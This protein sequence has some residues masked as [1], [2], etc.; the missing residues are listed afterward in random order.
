[1]KNEILKKYLLIFL[2]LI[3]CKTQTESKKTVSSQSDFLKSKKFE[4][5]KNQFGELTNFT[6]EIDTL[7][8]IK[9]DNT[10]FYKLNLTS[11]DSIYIGKRNDTI[12][13]FDQTIKFREIFVILNKKNRGNLSRLR[14]DYRVRLDNYQD[15][16]F[17]FSF[18][19]IKN[20]NF[21][22][23]IIMGFK[24]PN[25]TIS[26]MD[27]TKNGKIVDLIIEQKENDK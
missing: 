24:Y 6:F 2:I 17:K 13:S 4:Q 23:Y 16:L 15:S 18:G 26:K 10:D 8:K 22:D 7:N 25:L 9:Y 12:F 20:G 14:T 27:I 11:Y 1:M 5:V 21:G 3:S 19:K